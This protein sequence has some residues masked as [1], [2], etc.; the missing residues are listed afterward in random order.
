MAALTDILR[1]RAAQQGQTV[2]VDCGELGVLT[3]EALPRRELELLSRGADPERAVFYAACRELQA[4]G[5]EL[6]RSGQIYTP[7]GVMQFVSGQEAAAAAS[8]VRTLSGLPET[9]KLSEVRLSPVQENAA[10]LDEIRL[11]SVQEIRDGEDGGRAQ[12]SEI[13]LLPVQQTDEAAPSDGQV[14]RETDERRTEN[15]TLPQTDKKSQIL[16]ERST[17]TAQIVVPGQIAHAGGRPKDTARKEGLHEIGSDFPVRSR[18]PMHESKSELPVRL[19]EIES[20]FDASTSPVLH[21]TKSE[22]EGLLH[23]TESES[24]E[25]LHEAKPEVREMLHEMKSELAREAAQLLAQEL[26]RAALTR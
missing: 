17:E 4:M 1:Q 14:S 18:E 7:D 12:D 15:D 19:H 25:R 3:L 20:E 21:E 13:R 16:G 2:Q 8:A 26:R 24:G 9:D 5:E 6:R 22:P 11:P 23:E 10:P